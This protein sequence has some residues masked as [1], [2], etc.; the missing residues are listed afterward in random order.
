MQLECERSRVVKLEQS[1]A[2]ATAHNSQHQ[3]QVLYSWH[4]PTTP[5]VIAILCMHGM[6]CFSACLCCSRKFSM[7]T[8]IN[9]K[10]PYCCN[11]SAQGLPGAQGHW[12]LVVGHRSAAANGAGSH[13]AAAAAS[14]AGSQNAM[15]IILQVH[16]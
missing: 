6:A 14:D 11:P 1:L 5:H 10:V 3:D 8:L 12:H 4:M 9:Y 7:T 2:E 15:P 13:S 16:C